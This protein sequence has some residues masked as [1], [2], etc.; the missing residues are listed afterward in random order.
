MPGRTGARRADSEAADRG[1]AP[2]PGFTLIEMLVV[3]T[4]IVVLIAILLPALRKARRVAIVLVCRLVYVDEDRCVWIT[5]PEG[6]HH[7]QV[8]SVK[9]VWHPRW[10]PRGDQIAYPC[11]D[12]WV[13][14]EP[15]S[16]RI[17]IHVM[18]LSHVGCWIDNRTLL[19]WHYPS[20]D[21]F[22][23][24][25]ESGVMSY[26][27]NLRDVS[28]APVWPH[29]YF[30]P[31]LADGFVMTEAEAVW[32]PQAD[33]VVRDRNWILR[34]VVWKDP[35]NDHEDQ[36]ATID[37]SG[38]WIGWSHARRRGVS[39]PYWVAI[40]PSRASPLEQPRLLG[41]QFVSTRF[42]DWLPDATAL[43]LTWDSVQ[44]ELVVMSKDG[45]VLRHIPT[46]IP[47]PRLRGNFVTY[48][49]SW[50]HFRRF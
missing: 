1:S 40:K 39:P 14:V 33:V 12:G 42:C 4:L 11:D 43:V 3:I 13:I 45:A 37:P 6:K 47:L 36:G 9:P 44:S 29:A 26:W 21:M 50:R 30:D 31:H 38:Q 35:G 48:Q 16:G 23:V 20:C 18:P 27:L 49:P 17:T 32:S 8:S 24:E 41:D 10:S 34:K 19:I 22:T 28:D 7:L 25:A 2:R 15:V 46:A 5:D